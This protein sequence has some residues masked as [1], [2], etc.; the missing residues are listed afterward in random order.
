MPPARPVDRRD[1]IEALLRE[2]LAPTHVE[3]IDETVSHAG[4]EGARGG[5][6]H[7]RVTVVSPRFA[8]LSRVAAQ[9]LVHE[10]LTSELTSGLHALALRTYAPEQWRS[11]T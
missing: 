1:R 7:Y 5:Q 9:R 3:V 11:G 8:G 4:H 10:V 6:S 2:A